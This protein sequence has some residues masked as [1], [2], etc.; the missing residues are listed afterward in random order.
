MGRPQARIR[1]G[2]IA[3]RLG[4]L[5]LGAALAPVLLMAAVLAA[6]GAAAGGA[7]WVAVAAAALAGAGLAL[8]VAGWFSRR[9]GARLARVGDVLHELSA[10]VSSA[11]TGLADDDEVGAVGQALDRLFDRRIEAL[12]RAARDSE[13]L[14]DSVIEI[15]Q[16]VGTIASRK[17]LTIR[18]PVT[19]NVTGAIAD[20]LNLL[21]DETRRLLLSV[22]S[23]SQ[24]VARATVAVKS[25]SDTAARAAA[26]EQ[27]EVEFAAR[28]LAAAAQALDA[29]AARAR[30]CNDAAGRAVEAAGEA[31]RTVEGTVQGIAHSR[32]L[33]RETEKRI[34][35]L[36]ERSQEVGQVVGIIRDIAE[37]TG[38]LALN[39]SMQAAAAGPAGRSFAVVADEVKRL[40][41]SAR[42]ATV[43]IGDL[44]GAIQSETGET[45]VA[46][47][48][49]I[50]RIVQVSRLAEEAGAGMLR[51]REQTD[52]LAAT[53]RDIA[54]TSS[55]QAKVGAALQE[56]AR[57]IQ[58]ASNE[59][60]R[61]LSL[62]AAETLRLVE[63]AKAL[64]REVSVFRLSER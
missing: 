8:A 28:E 45:T 57:I 21:T 56:R 1:T 25:Q 31:M 7:L 61:Q 48:Q 53:V 30:A 62:Q 6:S 3:L 44:V 22:R 41:E 23:V 9:V 12:Q 63:S 18:V 13:E 10:G 35:R 20:A 39:A 37:R 24:D 2:P 5:V 33:I 58:E 14:N 59:T 29:I 64:M 51:T 47:N 49:A 55:E 42:S 27:R 38:I 32:S 15:M 16:A 26:R 50:S 34:K 19:E 11:R 54:R 4:L 17:D 60:A 40:S 46:M 52:A 36:G 43:E